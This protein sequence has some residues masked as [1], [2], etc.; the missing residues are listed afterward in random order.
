MLIS[1]SLFLLIKKLNDA[2]DKK[3]LLKKDVQMSWLKKLMSL[4]LV[5]LLKNQD[6][7]ISDIEGKIPNITGLANATA[8]TA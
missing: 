1:C 4:I 3:K 2:V 6:N 5:N 8:L 7:K